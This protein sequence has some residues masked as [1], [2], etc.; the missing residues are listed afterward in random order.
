MSTD[1]QFLVPESFHIVNDDADGR[2][3]GH[4]YPISSPMSLGSGELIS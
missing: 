2:T 4:E 1:F 3:P